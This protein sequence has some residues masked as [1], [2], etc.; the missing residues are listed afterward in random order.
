MKFDTLETAVSMATRVF[1][2]SCF[3]EAV[4]FYPMG[5]AQNSAVPML[6]LAL[7]FTSFELLRSYLPH[8]ALGNN[9]STG[10]EG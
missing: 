1:R 4:H 9:F 7:D 6:P 2:D 5:N 3:D 8:R 10:G